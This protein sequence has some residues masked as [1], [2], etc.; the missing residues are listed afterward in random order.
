MSMGTMKP[1]CLRSVIERGLKR[2]S[3]TGP[4]DSGRGPSRIAN[5]RPHFTQSPSSENGSSQLQRLAVG[6][7]SSGA[8]LQLGPNGRL[9]AELGSVIAGNHGVRFGAKMRLPRA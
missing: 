2:L 8:I 7:Q 5:S 3:R 6:G 4:S 1:M 9:M